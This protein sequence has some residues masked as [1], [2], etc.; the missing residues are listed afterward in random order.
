MEKLFLGTFLTYNKLDI[1]DQEDVVIPVLVPELCGRVVVLASDR[2][3]KVYNISYK[4][5]LIEKLVIAEA[6]WY[7][8]P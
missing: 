1:V 2:T 3:S 8:R 4:L 6:L 5:Y 7:L